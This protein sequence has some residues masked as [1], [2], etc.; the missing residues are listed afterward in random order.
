MWDT[1]LWL[2]LKYTAMT[3]TTRSRKSF[4]RQ[5]ALIRRK[6][7]LSKL[8]PQQLRDL[9]LECSIIKKKTRKIMQELSFIEQAKKISK[10]IILFYSHETTV[11]NEENISNTN[12]IYKMM[13]ENILMIKS[14]ENIQFIVK[15]VIL[16]NKHINKHEDVKTV[17][18]DL[19]SKLRQN[20]IKTV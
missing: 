7:L 20:R 11:V 13:I 16:S 1:K 18:M 3:K 4:S 15:N 12:K 5:S 19:M 9:K 10:N 8:Y 2:L 17:F 14:N 6:Q